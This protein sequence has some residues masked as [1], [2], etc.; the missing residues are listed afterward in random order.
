MDNTISLVLL[1]PYTNSR[2]PCQQV[3][4]ASSFFD[5]LPERS[6]FALGITR[7]QAKVDV[8]LP[9]LPPQFRLKLIEKVL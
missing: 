7:G 3:Q 8:N 2:R 4:V 5:E 6:F 9:D 1:G